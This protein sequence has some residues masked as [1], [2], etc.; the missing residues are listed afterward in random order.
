MT[1]DEHAVFE[2]ALSKWGEHER[3]PESGVLIS[4]TGKEDNSRY[5]LEIAEE[6]S[7]IAFPGLSSW[8]SRE[9]VGRSSAH[10]ATRGLL[11]P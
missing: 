7:L 9:L 10:E 3:G 2:K 11:T 6:M 8:Y 4:F 1:V 5:L